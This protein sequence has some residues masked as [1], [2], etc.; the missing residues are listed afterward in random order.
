MAREALIAGLGLIGGSIGIAL[1]RRG[2]RVR[3]VD[4]HVPLDEAQRHGAADV[5]QEALGD[6]EVVILATPVD[7]AVEQLRTLRDAHGVVTSV[8]SV[9]APLREAAQVRFVAGHPLAGSQEHGLAAA[10]GELFAGKRWFVDADEPLVDA[11]IADCGAIRERVD[12]AA[13][14]KAVALTSHL[15]QVL[16]TALAAYLADRDL[17]R[18]A[19]SGLA[20]FLRLAGSDASV[21]SPVLEA[22]RANLAPHVEPLLALVR[23]IIDGDPA[24]FTKANAL[25]RALDRK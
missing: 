12:A 5:R 16:S 6:A 19:G 9:L 1:R 7:I 22:N 13:H 20:T 2:W 25:T 15:P 17:L 14:D 18:F 11:V 4:P 23:E 21:W 8:C 3:Y 10:N 24:A